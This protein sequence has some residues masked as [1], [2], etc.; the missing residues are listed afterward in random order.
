VTAL[1]PGTLAVACTVHRVHAPRPLTVE[2]HHVIPQAWQQVF[3]GPLRPEP[4]ILAASRRVPG[5]GSEGRK[6]WDARTVALCP[7]GH[8]NV[9][10]WIVRIMH[11]CPGED[12]A[13]ATHLAR[14]GDR[15]ARGAE[16]DLAV[17]A[18]TRFKDAGGQLQAL[19]AARQWG[20][21]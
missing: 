14:H 2:L 6:L 7:T 4:E 8:R 5:R 20:E 15:R 16:F 9:H 3:T 18:L 21:A 19:V 13:V 11:L 17:L 1:R 12:P 10:A